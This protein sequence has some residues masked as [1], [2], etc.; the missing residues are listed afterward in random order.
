MK[1]YNSTLKYEKQIKQA[2]KTKQG[3]RRRLLKESG[4]IKRSKRRQG[5]FKKISKNNNFSSRSKKRIPSPAK[6]ESFEGYQLIQAGS[7]KRLE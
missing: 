4:K 6:E 2:A 1:E 5:T 3:R 7:E